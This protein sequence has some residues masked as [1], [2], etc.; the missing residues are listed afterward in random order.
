MWLSLKASE[1][2]YDGW[3]FDTSYILMLVIPFS[4]NWTAILF[5]AA[6]IIYALH[7]QKLGYII[8]AILTVIVVIFVLKTDII[9]DQAAF[10]KKHHKE[11]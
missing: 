6:S 1:I 7:D 2:I 3:V 10:H 9:V 4:A 5:A 11:K 8:Y